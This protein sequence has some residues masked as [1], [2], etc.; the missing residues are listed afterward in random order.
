M[1]QIEI[2]CIGQTAIYTNTPEIFSGDVN[3][4][5]VKFTFDEAWNGYDMKTAVFYNNPKD[6]YPVM[7][8]ENDVAVIP[9]A[10]MAD[11]CKLSIGVFGTNANG[12]VKTSKILTYNIG[13]GAISNDLEAT[14]PPE[15]WEQLLTRQ[16]KFE[17]N[18]DGRVSTL[19]TDITNTID[20]IDTLESIVK[21]RNQA[22]AYTSY[23]EMITTL[24]SMGSDELIRGQNIYIGEVG[25]P[26]LW[27]YAVEGT[28]VEYTYVDDLTFV[29]NMDANTTIQVGYYKLAQLETQE[30]DLVSINTA[31]ENLDDEIDNHK[32]S[33]V[34]S[35]EGTHGIRYHNEALEVKDEEDKWNNIGI[36]V[37]IDGAKYPINKFL[38]KCTGDYYPEYTFN[39][40][41]NN[42]L[43][44]L[45]FQDELHLIQTKIHYKYVNGELTQVYTFSS[46]M[47]GGIL[48]EFRNEMYYVGGSNNATSLQKFNG[49]SWETLSTPLPYSFIK[50]CA[51]VYENELHIIGSS[52]SSYRKYHYKYDGET[53]SI[54]SNL[55]VDFYRSS[56]LNQRSVIVYEGE[57]HLFGGTTTTN[58]YKF[59]GTSWTKM[60]TLPLGFS[61]TGDN[62]VW[63]D[64][65]NNLRIMVTSANSDS[66]LGSYYY[67]NVYVYKNGAWEEITEGRYEGDRFPLGI[68]NNSDGTRWIIR[69]DYIVS[70]KICESN[71]LFKGFSFDFNGV[72]IDMNLH[73]NDEKVM[74]GYGAKTFMIPQYVEKCVCKISGAWSSGGYNYTLREQNIEIDAETIFADTFTNVASATG[75][76]GYQYYINYMVGKGCIIPDTAKGRNGGSG[77][78]EISTAVQ[79]TFLT[80]VR[81]K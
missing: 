51:V 63:V 35:E 42:N 37:D 41:L 33:A 32:T 72:N 21:G 48:I 1:A 18:I 6:T 55:P 10:V 62:I 15:F 64:D 22:L 23:S 30:V 75:V 16:I 79:K 54:V 3:I 57:I 29:E 26:D 47:E 39:V 60:S 53:W 65:E 24:N 27:V 59:D 28:S 81:Y 49:T 68:F 4:D 34:E 36:K 43:N 20:E 73:D 70:N 7:L 71:I 77:Y 19:E 11:K 40:T 74:S 31:I 78:S 69:G 25:V 13:K 44:S 8:D 50:G 5:K 12:D 66:V 9:E 38:L 67:S 58:H 17:N 52:N 45:M 56:N 80:T 46:S 76:S 2:N 14:T 61:S